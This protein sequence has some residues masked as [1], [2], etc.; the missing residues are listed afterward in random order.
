[1]RNWNR[2]VGSAMRAAK[3]VF[4]QP[5]EYRRQAAPNDPI[6]VT[7]IF[8]PDYLRAEPGSTAPVSTLGPML[9]VG[10]DALGFTPLGGDTVRPD[11]AGPTYMIVDVQPDGA[12]NVLCALHEA[13]A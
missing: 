3:R 2:V 7:A 13:P 4:G 12:G 6:I 9:E 5:V 8:D 10:I 11:P 1:M